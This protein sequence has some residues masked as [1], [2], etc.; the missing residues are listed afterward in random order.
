MCHGSWTLCT[1]KRAEQQQ[2]FRER[3]ASAKRVA[4]VAQSAEQQQ[5]IRER[6]ASAR[7]ATRAAQL[8]E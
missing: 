6:D 2:A 4:M 3:D 1:M 8:A 7:R 5:V